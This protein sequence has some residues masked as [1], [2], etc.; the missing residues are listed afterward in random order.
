MKTI[1]SNRGQSINITLFTL[2]LLFLNSASAQNDLKSW[3]A[4]QLNL[5]L[6][7]K[8]DFRVGYLRAYNISNGFANDFSQSTIHLGYDLTKRFSLGAGAVIGSLSSADGANRATLRATYK[9]PVAGMLN[10]SNALQG[11]IHSTNE[12][13]YRQ[14]VLLISKLSTKKKLSP[15]RLSPSV[16]Y[17]LFYNIGGDPL[18][19]Y[20]KTGQATIRQTPDGFHRGRLSFNLNSKITRHFYLAVY[21]MM[22]R[23]F[24]LWADEYHSINVVNPTTG[25]VQRRFQDYNVIGTTLSFDLNLYKK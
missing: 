18:Q 24:N 21:Y 16:S 8:L 19:Y 17:T 5:S 7:Q 14:R 11:E 9:V 3:N 22:Q 13:R 23:E 10:W 4:A 25:K 1:R 6:T 15:L 12:N 20:D 2:F